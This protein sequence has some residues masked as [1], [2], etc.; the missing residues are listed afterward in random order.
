MISSLLNCIFYLFVRLLFGQDQRKPV[1]A[2]DGVGQLVADSTNHRG[3]LFQGRLELH[4]QNINHRIHRNSNVGTTQLF[5]FY[6][7]N[8]IIHIILIMKATK[9]KFRTIGP[10]KLHFWIIQD[11]SNTIQ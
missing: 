1:D 10:I 6:R 4:L 7:W 9:S 8:H 5:K 3:Q 11:I 2:F